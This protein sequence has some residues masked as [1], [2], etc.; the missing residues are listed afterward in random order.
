MTVQ[1]DVT[2]IIA[3]LRKKTVG[4][5]A[6]LDKETNYI[7][8]RVMY[9]GIDNEFNGYL[10]S[11]KGSA[12]IDQIMVFPV[13]SFLVFGLEE[14]YD[15]SWEVEVD[16]EARLLT[17]PE[18]IDYALKE[19]RERNPFADVAIESGIT[20]QFDFIKLIPR[21]I[22]FRFYGEALKGISPTVLKI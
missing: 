20:G 8:L 12:K 10:M 15:Q 17:Q 5:I 4:I 21:I 9:Y 16:G 2:E 1:H 19:L 14:P 11:T 22:R 7:R 3:C 13:T 18:D 6:T